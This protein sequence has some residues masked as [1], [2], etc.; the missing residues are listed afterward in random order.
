MKTSV[1]RVLGLLVAAAIQGVIIY[2]AATGLSAF[3]E[4][5]ESVLTIASFFVVLYIMTAHDEATYQLLW[6]LFVLLLPVPGTLAYLLYGHKRSGRKIAKKLAAPE[7]ELINLYE[8]MNGDTATGLIAPKYPRL[9]QT[10]NTIEKKTGYPALIAGGIE[11][12]PLGEKLYAKM[13]EEMGKASHFIYCEYFIIEHGKM[14]DQMEDIMAEKAAQ[15]VKVRVMYDDLGSIGTYAPKEIARLKERGIDCVRFNPVQ[16]VTGTLNYRDHRKMLI[17]D[18]TTAFSGGVNLADEYINEVVKFGHWKDIGFYM[19]GAPVANYTHMFASFWNAFSNDKVSEDEYTVMIDNAA[20]FVQA[21]AD[22]GY[23]IG[24]GAVLSYYDNPVNDNNISNDLFIDLLYQA[25]DYI[26]FYTPYLM[27]GASLLEAFI[28]AAERG[29][30]VRIVTP[31]VPDKKI[32]LRMTRSY[33]SQLMAAGVKIYEYTPGFVHAKACIM[34]DHV[35]TTGTVN[36]DY[37]S[38]FLHFENNTIFVDTRQ[39]ADLKQDMLETMEKCRLQTE[40][41]VHRKLT[42]H[43]I[44]ELLRIFTPLC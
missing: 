35:A 43:I 21:E 41:D 25:E 31:G 39:I 36:L 1:K 6:L 32:I 27:P 13:L 4:A 26:W 15:G 3:A 12:Y 33:Y 23:D 28:K 38:L 8:R 14:W 37:R 2:F 10:L 44:D 29:V 19:T 7:A 18:G 22:G 5:F 34:D 40:A 42:G 20:D 9:A 17:I 16:Y 30:D 11:Y 24:D